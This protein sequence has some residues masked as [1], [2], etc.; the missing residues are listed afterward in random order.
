MKLNVVIREVIVYSMMEKGA[1]G[2]DPRTEEKRKRK[3]DI[4]LA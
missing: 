1:K 2:L 3:S 4:P